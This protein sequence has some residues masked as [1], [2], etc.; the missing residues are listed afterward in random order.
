MEMLSKAL[1][2]QIYVESTNSENG[3]YDPK[4]SSIHIGLYAGQ[5]SKGTMLFTAA[6][7]LTH[8]IRQWSPA[9]FK[10]LANFLISQY[11]AKGVSVQELID[12]QIAKAKRDGRTLDRDAAYEEVIADSM[13]TMLTDGNVLQQLAELRQRDQTLWEKIKGWFKDF[14]NKLKAVIKTYDGVKP[15]SVE[16]RLVSDMKGVVEI[17]ESLYVDALMD[18]SA[19]YAAGAQKNT[20]GGGVKYSLKAFEDGTRFVDVQMDSNAFDGMTVAQMNQEAKKILMERFAG[21]VI[22][23]ENRVFV[24]G[25][26]VN[27]YLH[28]SKAIDLDTRKAKLTASGELDNLLDAGVALPNEPDG[29]DGHI[30]PDAIDFSYYK[31]VFKVGT[32]YF[33]GIVNVKNIKRGK[34]FKDVTK[35]RNITKDIVSS[36]GQNP[37][38]NFLRD[39]SMNS[40]SNDSENVNKK[41]SVRDSVGKQLSEAQ[42]DYFRDSQ[43][44]D[45]EGCLL[46]LYHQ[47]DGDFTIFDTRHTGA[48]SNDSGTPFGIFLK[49]SPGDIGLSGKKKMA[50]YANITNPLRATNREDLDRQLRKISGRYAAISDRLKNLDVEYQRKIDQAQTTWNDYVKK[51]RE[52]NPNAKRTDLYGDPKFN[53]LFHAEDDLADEWTTVSDRLSIQAKEVITEDLRKAGHDGIFLEEDAGSWGRRTDAIIALDPNQVK[54]TNN[55]N[56]TD[57]PDIHYSTRDRAAQKMQQ[58]LEKENAQLKEDIAYLKDLLALQRKVTGG[59][60]FTKSSVTAAAQMLKKNANAKGDT[61]ELATLL[62]TFYEYIA[63]ERELTWEGV[64]EQAL[65]AV[66]WLQEHT[67]FKPEVSEY[68]RDVLRQIRGSR[69]YLDE[70]QK[71]E[72][73]YRFGSFNDFRKSVMGSVTID[74]E[75]HTS[76]DSFWQEMSA[77]YPDIFSSETASGDMPGE[78]FD[79]IGRLRNSD[80]SRGEYEHI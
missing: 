1:G 80:T 16:G 19:N 11:Y 42:Q 72:A 71:A 39:A 34:L 44:R 21:R 10:V 46:V 63:T 56:P 36:Y 13:E 57:S 25:D 24:N 23:I 4:D 9:K 20:A 5:D 51:W 54:D 53:E 7:E 59:T 17:L 67:V 55:Q 32:E 29:K 22:G 30:H 15:D 65:P 68:A 28:P 31:T 45:K 14:A 41:F 38:S 60:K 79:I 48:G 26:S 50:L 18:A 40:I 6:H 58:A 27:E 74:N 37:K 61:K 8:F 35:I 66:K 73:A 69:I 33:E 75:G 70:S 52:A 47:T 49:R 12:G 62:N 2:V 78:L 77:S 64:K 3:W 43:V 76:L